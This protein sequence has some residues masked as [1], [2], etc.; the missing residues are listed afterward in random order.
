[1]AKAIYAFYRRL[2]SKGEA[3]PFTE[4]E[5]TKVITIIYQTMKDD[6]DDVV[7]LCLIFFGGDGEN[8]IFI[9][10]NAKSLFFEDNC[11]AK[12]IENY[13]VKLLI[14]DPMSLYIREDCSMNN[15]NE[16]WAEFNYLIA[17]A[18]DT[19]VRL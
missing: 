11:I 14:L 2:R 10:K 15:I 16:I 17:A 9:K 5:G 18:K 8:L 13:Y 12:A 19:A 7:A 6:A 3:L 1:M 4:V